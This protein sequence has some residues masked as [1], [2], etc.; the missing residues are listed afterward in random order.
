MD[1]KVDIIILSK[2]DTEELKKMT[3]QT[4]DSCHASEKDIEFNI[5]VFEQIHGVK[6]ENCTTVNY[7]EDF[8][9]NRLMNRGIAMSKNPYV[10]LCNNDLLFQKGWAEK[11]IKS[12]YLSCSPNHTTHLQESIREGYEI[13]YNGEVK[14]WCIFI[15]RKLFDIIGKIDESV[16]FWYSDN[17]YADQLKKHN[18]KHAL[19][20]HATVLHLES[21]TLNLLDEKTKHEYTSGQ[22]KLYKKQ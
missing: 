19:I 22:F 14:G 17:V 10:C 4:I 15:D 7:I 12:G 13:S 3:Q 9:Y 11:C 16:M 8:H 20:R 18:V 21:K 6:Y 1:M 5:V 2:G